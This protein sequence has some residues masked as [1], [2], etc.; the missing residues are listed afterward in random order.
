MTIRFVVLLTLALTACREASGDQPAE[1]A[2]RVTHNVVSPP[3]SGC[4]V[5]LPPERTDPQPILVVLHGNHETA[6]A[7]SA[8]WRDAALAKG[9]AVLG[10]T[11]PRHRGCDDGKWYAWRETP[12]FVTDALATIARDMP[13]DPARTYLAGWSGGA[14]AIGQH[15]DAWTPFAGIVIHG[16]GQAPADGACPSRAVPVYFLVGDDNPAHAAAIRL[17]EHLETC[18]ARV[19]WDLLR[20]ANH[21]DEKRALDRDK[22]EHILDWLAAHASNT[23]AAR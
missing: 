21:A 23:V 7:A 17:R 13:L 20:G 1:S 19:E 4:T 16:G 11:C 8:R 3:C 18:A 9:F 22:G 14:S 5:D 2:P 15:L 12:S 6:T 10:L